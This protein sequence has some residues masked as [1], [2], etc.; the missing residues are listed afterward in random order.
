ML[1]TS[2]DRHSPKS[3]DAY[4]KFV[5][6]LLLVGKAY[7]KFSVPGNKKCISQLTSAD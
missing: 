7:H 6:T 3:R 1:T 2:L 4:Q 5:S